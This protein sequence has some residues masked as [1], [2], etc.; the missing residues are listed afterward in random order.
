M[1]R[2]AEV[3]VADDGPGIPAEDQARVFERFWRADPARGRTAAGGAGLGLSIVDSLVRAHGG[4]IAVEQRAGPGDGLH[5]A[6]AAGISGP[7]RGLISRTRRRHPRRAAAAC[8]RPA[9]RSIRLVGGGSASPATNP[10]P[11]RHPAGARPCAQGEGLFR[12]GSPAPGGGPRSYPPVGSSQVKGGSTGTFPGLPRSSSR[13][14]RHVS[15]CAH[16]G[17]EWS[18][19]GSRQRAAHATTRG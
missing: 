16:P 13:F 3:T 11:S 18:R 5:G 1:A 14:R 4:T 9:F 15:A 12:P 10:H 2:W 19:P 7:R 8:P 17:R 6:A